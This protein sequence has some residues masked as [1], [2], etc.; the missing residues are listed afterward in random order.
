MISIGIL[1]QIKDRE[2]RRAVPE[3]TSK[4]DAEKAEAIFKADLFRGK[5]NL[6][7]NKADKLFEELEKAYTEYAKVNKRSWQNERG[8]VMHLLSFF[9]GIRLKEISPILIEKYRSM[10]KKLRKK[11]G[12]PL[13][14][15][16][17]NREM[18]ILRKMFSI[19]IDNG[20]LETNPCASRK[21]KPL[22]EDNTQERYL[23]RDEETDLLNACKGIYIYEA[24]SYMCFEYRHEKR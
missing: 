9:G 17:I 15:A 18:E 12:S 11:E 3:A 6:V 14:N 7:E 21:V 16:T 1:F 2:Y 5:Y 13:K 10:K 19:A 22:R 20:W 4:R 23:E 8:S 24:Y